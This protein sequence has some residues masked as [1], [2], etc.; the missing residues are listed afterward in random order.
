[1]KRL[2]KGILAGSIALGLMT[3]VAYADTEN[4]NLNFIIEKAKSA[5]SEWLLME[6]QLEREYEDYRSAMNL[7]NSVMAGRSDNESYSYEDKSLLE[8]GP[9][10]A[11]KSLSDE[12]YSAM[13]QENALML[14]AVEKYYTFV[15]YEDQVAFI[16]KD[17]D[18][19]KEKLES[20]KLEFELGQITE[21]EL[22]EFEKTYDETYLRLLQAKS[23]FEDLR[24][25]YN[26]FIGKEPT[27]KVEVA[28][29][30]IPNANFEIEDVYTLAN[31]V[32]E[33]SYQVSTIE[34][35][36]AIAEKEK[37]LKSRFKG[38]GDVATE[39]DQLEDDIFNY[40]NQL[41]T[42][43]RE[44]KYDVISKYNDV[45]IAD[46]NYKISELAFEIA[47]K[48]YDVAVL[49]YDNGLVSHQDYMDARIDFEDAYY[50]NAEAKLSHYIAVSEFD[51]YIS[52]NTAEF[53][54]E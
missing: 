35:A 54:N 27:S 45:L 42:K 30:A 6:R 52:E 51:N 29:V 31:E 28:A 16:Q 19:M 38:F 34:Q 43:A 14:E 9:L 10:Q 4:T 25:D 39:L 33:K 21:L 48:E 26:I 32:A 37:E 47:K 12:R 13:Q 23:S 53:I 44:L 36:K 5:N 24:A 17:Y 49:K 40:G 3:S 2:I 7:S 20:K 22:M 15:N 41:I 18:Q 11:N 1:M 46:T 50:N 8:L